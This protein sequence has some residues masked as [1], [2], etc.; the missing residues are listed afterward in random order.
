MTATA[1]RTPILVVSC[2]AYADLWRP[3][4][5]VFWR[6][7]PDC[8]FPVHLGSNH[9]RFDD[10]RVT[11]VTVGEDRGW[12]DGVRRM[13]DAVGSDY[14]IFFLEDFFL[15][16]EVDT[17]RVRRLVDLARRNEVGCLRL[18][19]YGAPFD[20]PSESVPGASEVGRV[21][22][23]HPY[24]VSAQVAVWRTDVLRSLLVPGFSP[25]EFEFVGS[26][27]S[28]RLAAEFWEVLTP[29]IHYDHGVEKGK[30][31]PDG[32]AICAGAGVAIDVAARGVFSP[33]DLE[34]H[35]QQA[36]PGLA[37]FASHHAT[38]AH[39]R[40]GRRRE[41]VR[42]ALAAVSREPLRLKMWAVLLIGVLGPRPL[43]WLE[44]VNLR[45]KLARIG[46][47]RRQAAWR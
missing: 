31:K 41:G 39:F 7:W 1:D 35:L 32:I 3:F 29:V 18:T 37:R 19:R 45:W 43:H 12:A 5:E 17:S 10:E 36:E 9:R 2:D 14:V 21:A 6:R 40:R 46:L 28:E 30:W 11:A 44:E 33:A 22:K 20:L 8:P 23:G 42:S 25:W 4:F 47:R 34:R 24:R 13:L 15:Q 26:P 16:R 27:L 38:M